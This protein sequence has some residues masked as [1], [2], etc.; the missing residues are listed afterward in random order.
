MRRACAGLC[1]LD[2]RLF[3]PNAGP[4]ETLEV[5]LEHGAER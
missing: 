2:R 1:T 5:V 4:A 3:V